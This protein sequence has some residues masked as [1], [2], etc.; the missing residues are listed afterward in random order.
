LRHGGSESSAVQEQIPVS[1]TRGRRVLYVDMA[2]TYQTVKHKKHENFFET[3]HSGDFFEHVW[4]VHPLADIGGSD[5]RS[6]QTI[7]FSP[8]Q[9]VIEGVSSSRNWPRLLAP[10]D[11]LLSQIALIRLLLRT[12][13]RND[14]DLIVA[15]DPVYSGMIGT[16]LKRFSGK[17]LAIGIY[18]NYDLAY[19]TFGVVAMPRL[20]PSF[21]V[22]TFIAERVLRAADLVI[23]GN[24]DNL[25]W[26]LKHGANPDSAAVI[27]IARNVQPFHMAEPSARGDLDGAFKALGIPLGRKYL[28]MISRLIPVKFAEDGVRAMIHAVKQSE[29]LVAIVA[30]DGPMR[31]ELEALV[32]SEGLTDR[33][34]FIGHVDQEVLSRVIPRC[35]TVS[36]LTG[37]ALV[38]SGLGGSPAVAYDADWQA[39]FVEDGVNG[40]IVPMWDYRQMGEKALSLV[41]DEGLYARMSSAM[42]EIARRR[43]D[44]NEIAK[45]EREIFSRVL[46]RR[47]VNA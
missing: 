29:E 10:L 12:I 44:R 9:T 2:H 3:R 4:G 33:I 47:P 26:G 41:R 40:Y 35:I 14:I 37:M 36:P 11:L 27:P 46:E 13:K 20:I 23:G 7:E 43:A 19:E 34:L 24:Q 18:A 32:A 22:Q 30:G 8:R 42:R 17:P 39:E 16:I 21:K 45:L 15:T 28:L 6:I 1:T 38:E 31:P 5:A 25:N